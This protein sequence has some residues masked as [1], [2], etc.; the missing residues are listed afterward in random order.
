MVI[1]SLVATLNINDSM[2]TVM[3]I[4]DIFYCYVECRT[5]YAECRYVECH[6]AECRGA[7]F[8]F[9]SILVPVCKLY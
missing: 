9:L 6:Y 4:V 8:F 3:L 7:V 5:L 1:I 2:N